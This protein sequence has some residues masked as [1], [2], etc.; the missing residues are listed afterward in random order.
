[1][2]DFSSFFLLIGLVILMHFA[3]HIESSSSHIAATEM[4]SSDWTFNTKVSNIY[5]KQFNNDLVL[6][7]K[8]TDYFLLR[9]F[10]LFHSFYI[11]LLG[12]IWNDKNSLYQLMLGA[13]FSSISFLFYRNQPL[14]IERLNVIVDCIN[15]FTLLHMEPSIIHGI[16]STKL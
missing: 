4:K 8:F 6:F 16:W 5:N 15:L 12:I 10:I 13:V 11:W 7:C 14:I 3:E 1:M 9:F 2:E